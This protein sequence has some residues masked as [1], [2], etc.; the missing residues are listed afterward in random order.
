MTT[1]DVNPELVRLAR[2][3]RGLTQTSLAATAGVSQSL[4]AKYEAGVM[5]VAPAH[6]VLLSNALDYPTR[7]FHQSMGRAGAGSEV[8]HRK[9]ARIPAGVL[10]RTY[11]DATV[12]RMEVD[13]LRE[14]LD[15]VFRFPAFP[16]YPI[17]EF[18]YDTER[19][20]RTVRAAWQLPAGPVFNV[21]RTVEENGGIVV[22]HKFDNRID[23]FG[24][25]TTGLPPVFHLNRDLPPDRWRWTL[26]H[27]IGHMVMH[28]EVANPGKEAEDQAHRFAGEFLAPGP[29][30]GT[31]TPAPEHRQAG[32]PQDGMENLNAG[33]G[34]TRPGCGRYRCWA[35]QIADGAVVQKW[36]PDP[37]AGQFGPARGAPLSTV[38]HGEV[39][40]TEYG[41]LAIRIARAPQHRR[42]GFLDILP[43]SGRPARE[44]LGA[45]REGAA[46]KPDF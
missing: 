33:A 11:A 24:C 38:R 27:E 5:A 17:E 3:S 32:S 15:G 20:A 35:V 30:T 6:L 2:Q 12:R 21:T 1:R 4:I 28:S 9:R 7:F 40:P 36:L 14:A 22:A 39:F 26:A 25:R 45:A 42:D 41:V 19:I 43:R 10:D 31:A 37:R 46:R 29:P 8:F 13:A 34:E 44:H 18:D 23:G 16:F